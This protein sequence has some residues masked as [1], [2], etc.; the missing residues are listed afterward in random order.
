MGDVESIRPFGPAR[1]TVKGTPLS[2]DEIKSYNDYFKASCYLALGMIYLKQNPLLREP[3]KKEH[4]KLRLLGHFGSAPGQIFTYMHFNRMIK[5]FDLDA[6]FV[7][8]PGHGAP[9]VLSQS[10]LEGVY[11]EVYPDK[12]RDLEGL[13]KVRDPPPTTMAVWPSRDFPS[14]D[15]VFTVLQIL[16]LPGRNRLSCHARDPRLHP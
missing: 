13:Q 4:L 7:S 15:L 2:G 11:S 1:S 6:Y 10:Y 9:G 12:S 5:K 8:G 14:A 16:Q 3:L